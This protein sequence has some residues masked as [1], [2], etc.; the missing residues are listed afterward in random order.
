[1]KPIS[2]QEVNDYPKNNAPSFVI[3]AINN[4]ISSKST[5]SK[6]SFTI[7]HSEAKNKILDQVDLYNIFFNT[8]II[9]DDRFMDFEDFYMKNDWDVSYVKKGIGDTFES[10]YEFKPKNNS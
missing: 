1:M 3:D 10:Y 5:H 6:S 8:N 4:L 7:L 9:W 2:P